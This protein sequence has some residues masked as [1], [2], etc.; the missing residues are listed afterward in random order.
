M[1]CPYTFG[2]LRVS[3]CERKLG[4]GRQGNGASDGKEGSECQAG[5]E[6]FGV[7]A[8]FQ[9][10]TVGWLP[11]FRRADT[12]V[13][14]AM[15]PSQMSRAGKEAKLRLKKMGLREQQ[16]PFESPPTSHILE[17][18]SLTFLPHCPSMVPS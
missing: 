8:E 2:A 13:C 16:D 1:Q 12:K 10:R 9:S 11:S 5:L 3:G 17:L 6:S 18:A 15:M 4:H 7:T 14:G